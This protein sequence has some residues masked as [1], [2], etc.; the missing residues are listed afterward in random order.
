MWSTYLG[1]SSCH[2]RGAF[3]TL[4]SCERRCILLFPGAL[5]GGSMGP[6]RLSTMFCETLSIRLISFTAVV[7]ICRRTS[8]QAQISTSPTLRPSI[9]TTTANEIE[10]MLKY[11]PNIVESRAVPVAALLRALE[12]CEMGFGLARDIS[13]YASDPIANVSAP[14]W[15][16]LHAN[17]PPF[18][19][20]DVRTHARPAGCALRGRR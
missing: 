6:A 16:Y 8:R 14:A 7:N 3:S 2:P 11:S 13:V 20:A 17:S 10:R 1:H 9:A 5:G 19:E 12:K 18:D 15:Q 4:E